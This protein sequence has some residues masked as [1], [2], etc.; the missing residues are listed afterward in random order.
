LRRTAG[1]VAHLSD[2]TSR[3]SQRQFGGSSTKGYELQLTMRYSSAHICCLLLCPILQ[4]LLLNQ[5]RVLEQPDGSVVVAVHALIALP[6][7]VRPGESPC[8]C[9]WADEMMQMLSR[10]AAAAAAAAWQCGNIVHLLPVSASTSVCSSMATRLLNSVSACGLAEVDRLHRGD[11][12][13]AS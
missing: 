13:C 6:N 3:A 10:A 5:P 8:H 11:L 4:A 7:V 9:S 1:A 2:P 12:H